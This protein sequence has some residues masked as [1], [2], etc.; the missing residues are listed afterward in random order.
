ASTKAHH[1]E[2]RRQH[3]ELWDECQERRAALAKEQR[4][5]ASLALALERARQE[6]LASSPDPARAE[7]RLEKLQR[8]DL[9]RLAAAERQVEEERQ[10]LRDDQA[11]LDRRAERLG[12]RED[13]V[14]ARQDE[15]ARQ[16]TEWEN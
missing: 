5:L 11:R 13:D 10:A 9:A 12:A 7:R 1:E 14:I 2:A 6:L 15:I 4:T 3:A 8:R 16:I